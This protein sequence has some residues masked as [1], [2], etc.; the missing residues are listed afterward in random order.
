MFQINVVSFNRRTFYATDTFLIFL[1][2]NNFHQNVT[3]HK[4][5]VPEHRYFILHCAGNK[6]C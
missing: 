4:H 5:G 6:I 2:L 3:V 1:F